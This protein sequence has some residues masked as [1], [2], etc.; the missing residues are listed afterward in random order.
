MK[1][2]FLATLL[3]A[4]GVTTAVQAGD[5]G[6][7]I[8]QVGNQATVNI[9][10]TGTSNTF[11]GLNPALGPALAKIYG[12][13]NQVGVTQTGGGNQL[14]FGLDASAT[15]STNTIVYTVTG[16]NNQGTI[17]CNDNGAGKCDHNNIAI[18]QTGD[19]N[20][21]QLA[22]VGSNNNVSLTTTGGNNNNYSFTGTGD[23]LTSVTNITGGGNGV[24]ISMM[25]LLGV[26]SEANV[27]LVGASNT[28]GITQSGGSVNGNYANV[29]IT[30]SGNSA[31]VTQSGTSADN[32]T[33]LQ[34][35]GNNNSFTIIQRA[36]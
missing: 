12:D 34:S 14:L 24:T 36:Q 3:L 15:G 2:K 20:T 17:D 11:A 27:T 16:S 6:V 5:N 9:T 23:H 26:A 22:M 1:Y 10:Q 8:D 32:V 18:T 19:G 21:T 33:R 25:P 28:V 35:S 31:S 4:L 30:G 7:Y 29:A 13:S